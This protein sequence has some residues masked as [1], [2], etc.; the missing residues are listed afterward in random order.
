MK[1]VLVV[2][3]I[4]LV[5]GIIGLTLSYQWGQSKLLVLDDSI[6]AGLPGDFIGL[7]DGVLSYYL[8]GPEQGEKV[9]LVHGFSTPKDVWG[10]TV[11]PLADAGYRVLAYDHYGRGFSDRPDIAYDTNLYTRELLNLLDALE[12]TEPVTLVGYSMGGGNV[13]G[14]AAKHPQRVK[15]LILIAPIGFMPEPSGLM[16]LVMLPGIGELL[17]DMSYRR[18]LEEGIKED[19]DAG[20]A[21]PAMQENFAEQLRY[22]GYV[23]ALLSTLRN[24]PMADLSGDYAIVGKSGIPVFAIWGTSDS[25][26]PF[27]GSAQAQHAIPTME[28][29][30]VE[31]AEHS[32][33]YAQ[34]DVVNKILLD[35]L[36]R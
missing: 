16:K 25:V 19:V 12:I 7:D 29:F 18:T 5:I 27:T 14:F 3:L 28:L 9:V 22:K 35:V 36:A 21:L 34:A 15:K 24:Y 8:R 6:R 2:I 32:V 31:N 23:P 11:G 1:L 13:I 10:A 30:P 17:M 33:T 4:I 20:N 26:V